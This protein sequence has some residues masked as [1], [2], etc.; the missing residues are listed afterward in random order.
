MVD[1]DGDS[2]LHIALAS[3][4]IPG[5]V[6]SALV[7]ALPDAI[8]Q[9]DSKGN[10]PLRIALKRSSVNQIPESFFDALIAA[11]P[12]IQRN[13][14]CNTAGLHMHLRAHSFLC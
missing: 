8:K 12:V 1:N 3:N 2:P 9:V 5:A 4:S 10:I 14:L 11:W 6:L 13:A 7:A